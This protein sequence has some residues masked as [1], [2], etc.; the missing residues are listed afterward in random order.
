MKTIISPVKY[1]DIL[2][3]KPTLNASAY[4][5]SQFNCIV[6]YQEGVLL[7]NTFTKE[8]V[9]LNEIEYSDFL[10]LDTKSDNFS[11]FVEHRFYVDSKINEIDLLKQVQNT[12]DILNIKD[13]V[14][15]FYVLTTTD[16]NARCY[17]C[18]ECGINRYSMTPQTAH[19]VVNYIANVSK[20]QEVT[21]RWFGG[22]PLFNV[23]AIDIIA[24]GL[25]EKNIKFNSYIT[26]NA[27][28][29]SEDVIK[30]AKE[31]WNLL[32]AQITIDGP[33]KK[34]NRIK[35]Y[36]YNT[37]DSPYK[38]VIGNIKNLLKNKI[39]V[40]IQIN[41]GKHTLGVENISEVKALID[42]LNNEFAEFENYKFAA[43]LIADTTSEKSEDPTIISN[44]IDAY[45]EIFRYIQQTGKCYQHSLYV[46]IAH[47]KCTANNFSHTF[48]MPNGD[49]AKCNREFENS[50]YG[51]IFRSDIDKKILYKYNNRL[52][53]I[54]LCHDCP[55]LPNCNKLK[56]CALIKNGICNE[57]NKQMSIELLKYAI[58][59]A[60]ED[61]L[62]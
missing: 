60:A 24:N 5:F 26:T 36:I 56:G 32:Y 17:Y 62:A 22:E 31:N 50:V 8:C 12:A 57:P 4:R 46:N 58:V 10:K 18:F 43:N 39:N 42:D 53:P 55:C 28:L 47:K 33:E 14:N 15:E 49:L 61:K 45:M 2:L 13:Y 41:I 37:D 11:Y 35:N 27:Y 1:V 19:E 59:G 3:G 20:G 44:V 52:E 51:N 29:F 9:M 21:I 25:K 54:E 16:C 23:E 48:I 7:H 34:Y 30:K 38:T 40:N 6:N